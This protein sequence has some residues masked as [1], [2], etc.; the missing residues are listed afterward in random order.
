MQVSYSKTPRSI[1]ILI[2]AI[3]LTSF[4]SPIFTF[5]LNHYFKISGPSQW[6]ALSNWGLT[7]GWLWQPLTYSFI[8]S[9]DVGITLSL[10]VSLFFHMLLLWF[11]GSEIQGRYGTRAFL[12]F[13]LGGALIAG[14]IAAA[15]LLAFS[16]QSVVIGS[17]PPIYALMMVWVMLNS[18]LELSFLF[19]IRFKAKWL[20]AILLGIALLVNLSY[21]EFIPFLADVV[22]IGWGFLIGRLVW[23]LPNPYPLNLEFPKRKKNGKIININVMQESDKAFMDRMLE[24]IGRKGERSLTKR[25]RQRMKNISERTK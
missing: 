21:G 15:A 3:V 16:S 13:Y 24:K 5:T 18:D 4:L 9:I 11:S 25:E 8:Q 7:R 12:L 2:W 17:A 22:G 23:K 10:L 14:M 19:L 1:K 6:F 20:V